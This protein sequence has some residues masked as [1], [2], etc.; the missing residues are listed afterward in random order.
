MHIF[1]IWRRLIM[2]YPAIAIYKPPDVRPILGVYKGKDIP[3]EYA[4]TEAE[5]KAKFIE[6]WQKNHKGGVSSSSFSG[7][8]SLSQ[9]S[10]FSSAFVKSFLMLSMKQPR[11]KSSVP[12]TYLEQKRQEAQQQ[13][14]EEQAYIKKHKDYLEGL[15]K[16]EQEAMAA[17]IPSNLWEALD[18]FQGKPLKPKADDASLAASASTPKPVAGPDAARK[19]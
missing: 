19:S 16:Q 12:L 7:L 14:L 15:L 8:F 11:Q 18:Q 9:V 6:E 13:Y 1:P 4:K 2:Q 5:G 17:Q 3:I 10:S